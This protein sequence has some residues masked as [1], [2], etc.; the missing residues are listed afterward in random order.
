MNQS[1]QG[2][3]QNEKVNLNPDQI[4]LAKKLAD[5]EINKYKLAKSQKWNRIQSIIIMSLLL[6]FLAI[7]SGVSVGLFWL[8][9]NLVN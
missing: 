6:P 1:K 2:T 5:I 8:F 3:K 9:Y 7:V 4:E